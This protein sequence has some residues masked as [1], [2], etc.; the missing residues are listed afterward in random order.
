MSH[1]LDTS[2]VTRVSHAKPGVLVALEALRGNIGGA[3]IAR[4]AMTDLEYGFSAE[5]E[6]QWDLRASD[7]SVYKLVDVE[8][9]DFHVALDLQRELAKAGLA[10]RKV[11]DLVIAEV[12]INNGLTL[13]HYDADFEFIATVSALKHGWIVARGS[14]D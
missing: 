13:V 2:V 10:K 5:N 4:C 14:T 9:I 7:L 11:P 12:A 6:R 3:N 1:L 8:P